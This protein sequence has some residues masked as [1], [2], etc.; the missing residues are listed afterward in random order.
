MRKTLNLH[1][2]KNP[3][4]VQLTTDPGKSTECKI[5]HFYVHDA[6]GVS[7][8]YQ[9]RFGDMLDMQGS[10]YVGM[11]PD[12][13]FLKSTA[14][15]ESHEETTVPFKLNN[16]TWINSFIVTVYRSG[17]QGTMVQLGNDGVHIF[18]EYTFKN[19]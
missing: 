16:D 12:C 18:I 2:T 13:L 9:V 15:G 1:L 7:P 19:M 5:I 6:N 11:K 17:E 8:Y 14:F 10:L 4:L 3:Q